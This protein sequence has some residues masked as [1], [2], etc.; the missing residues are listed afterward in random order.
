MLKKIISIQNVGRFQNSAAG[1]DTQFK[2]Y[3]FIHGANG[4][5][6]TTICTIFRS[7]VSGKGDYVVGRAMLGAAQPPGIELLM[8]ANA[9]LRFDGKN[10][11]STYPHLA[12]FDSLFVCENVHAGDIVDTDQKRGLYRVIVGEAGLA[13]AQQETQLATESR[14]KTSEIGSAEKA[15]KSHLPSGMKLETFIDLPEIEDLDE[16]IA[17]QESRLKTVSEA[18]TIKTR[19]A[20]AELKLPS[21]PANL[22]AILAATL[23]SIAEDAEQNVSAHLNAHGMQRSGRAWVTEG[24]DHVDKDCPFCGQDIQDAPLIGAYRAVF[25]EEYKRLKSS[26]SALQS[27]IDQLFGEVAA[28]RLSV[29]AEQHRNGVAYWAQHAPL[30]LPDYPIT[31]SAEMRAVHASLSA[32]VEIKAR[33][34]IDS[35]ELNADSA[36]AITRYEEEQRKTAAFNAAVVVANRLIDAKKI[37]AGDGN[38]S[39]IKDEID[40]L[41]AAKVRHGAGV[42]QLCTERAEALQKKA[43]IETQKGAVRAQLDSHTASVVRPY[44]DRINE[45]LD[46]FNAGFTISQT[47]HSYAGGVATSSYQIVINEKPVAVGNASSPASI[48]SFRN[49]LSAGDRSTLALAFFIAHLERNSN[50]ALSTVVFDDPFNSQDAFRRNQTMHEII[51][52]GRKCAQVIVLSHDATFLKQIWLKCEPANRSSLG[53]IDHGEQGSKIMAFDLEKACQGR[54]ANDIDDLLSYYHDRAGQPIDI[55]R[56]MR[57]VLETHLRATYPA[58]FFDGEWLGDMIGKIRDLGASHPAHHLYDKLNEIND[59][60]SYHH[61]EDLT[62]ITPDNLDPQELAG[63]VKRT[64][65]IVN[66]IQA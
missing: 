66:A 2:K 33:A 13:L 62:D 61:G 44:Q 34:P 23:D 64:L 65:R 38:T 42:A 5:G 20:L 40:R 48:P 29:S 30:D 36:A 12:I 25:S 26:I 32:L 53:I 6:K 55:V 9:N 14:A 59:S 45:L 39:P 1:G 41:K 63:L 37:E 35:I 43:E 24:L 49:T 60:A 16:Q 46:D 57:T 50:I 19:A 7:L 15:I 8:D 54:T 47:E 10:W 18:A 31:A 52:V 27:Q 56:K 11:S 51:K 4:H 22:A 3:T 28:D 21:V 17:A 58:H